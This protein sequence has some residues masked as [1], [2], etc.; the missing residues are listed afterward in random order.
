MSRF[1]SFH[2]ALHLLKHARR[3]NEVQLNE[4]QF[5]KRPHIGM[6]I[7]VAVLLS[8]ATFSKVSAQKTTPATFVYNP[9]TISLSADESV[10]H[11]CESEGNGG[12][13]HLNARAVSPDGNP[14]RYR[15]T[16]E[17]GLIEGEG[18]VVTWNIGRAKPGYYRAFLEIET[19]SGARECQAFSSTAVLVECPAIPVCPTVSISCPDK[20]GVDQPVTFS[21]VLS[22][23]LSNISPVYNWTVSAGRIIEGQGTNLIRVDTTGLAGQALTATLSMGGY[24]LDCSASC[25]VHFPVTQTCRRFDEFPDITRNDEKARLDNFAIELQN[26]PTSNAYVIIHPA[27]RGTGELQTRSR[28]IMDYLV[29]SRGLDP[30]RV[31]TRIGPSRPNLSVELW[32]CPQGTTPK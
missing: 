29:N 17:V 10:I 31:I 12:S 7:F 32:A 22:G 9:P 27:Q 14:I 18:P 16:S 25:P 30:R 24:N 3:G 2:K 13:V 28:R 8:S 11:A 26:D 1:G 20:V 4:M 19:G 5:F 6:A 21:A 15:W 23:P